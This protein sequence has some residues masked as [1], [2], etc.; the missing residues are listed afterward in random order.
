MGAHQGAELGWPILVFRRRDM[1]CA[2]W[3]VPACSADGSVCVQRGLHHL[4]G[5]ILQAA[6]VC[7]VRP[8]PGAAPIPRKYIASCPEER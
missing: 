3:G 2:R 5:N 4:C 7:F 6:R 8:L 1:G